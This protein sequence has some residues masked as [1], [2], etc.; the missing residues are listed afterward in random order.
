MIYS[1]IADCNYIINYP[2]GKIFIAIISFSYQILNGFFS[3]LYIG[4]YHISAFKSTHTAAVTAK[5]AA[6]EHCTAVKD[7]S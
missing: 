2:G 4:L 6:Q 1:R 5:K 3:V 7:L